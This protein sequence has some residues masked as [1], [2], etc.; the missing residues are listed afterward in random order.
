MAIKVL[1]PTCNLET[2]KDGRGGIYTWLPNE[3]IVEFN[4]LFL[5]QAKQEVFII[6][7]ILSN[8]CYALMETE[9]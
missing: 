9:F 3:P 2:V 1:Q 5:S 8:I 7:H 4:L 6:I